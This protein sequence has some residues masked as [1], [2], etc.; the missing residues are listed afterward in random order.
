MKFENKVVVISGGNAGIGKQTVLAFANEGAK[1]VILDLAL[2]LEQELEYS[3]SATMTDYLYLKCDVSKSAEVDLCFDKIL[4][5]FDTID[6]LINN[7][8]ILGNRAK[9]ED[10][11]PEEFKKV[12]EVNVFGVFYMLK[13]TLPIMSEQNSGAIVNVASVAGHLGM[14]QQVAY[15]ASKHAVMGIT[16]TAA[17]EYANKKIR[18][19]AV[20]PGFTE[21]AMLQNADAD[22]KY[23]EMLK[24]MTPMKR[25]GQA[26]EIAQAILFL[27]AEDSSFMTG[28]G[29]ILDGGLSIQ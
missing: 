16:K 20:C 29:I 26:H 12:I 4:A 21:T 3:L 2:G 5:Q 14:A 27:A 28:Q 22:E 7:A 25:Y 17:L 15:A 6:V 1:V 19:N 13:K 23:L 10:Y 18:I 11:E 24:F 9:I 8:G